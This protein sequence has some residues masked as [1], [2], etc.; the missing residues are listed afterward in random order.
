[1]TVRTGHLARQIRC[2]RCERTFTPGGPADASGTIAL[3]AESTDAT[4][5]PGKQGPFSPPTI[6][7]VREQPRKPW[8]AGQPRHIGRFEVRGRLGAGAFGTVYRAYDPHLDREVAL[9]VP[10]AGAVDS[11]KAVERFLREAK[12]AAGLRHPHIV[13][14]YDAGRDGD[15][16]YIASAFI[17]GRTLSRAISNGP[18]DFRQAAQIVHD[19]AEALGYAHALGIIHRDVKSSNVMLDDQGKCHLMDFG[20]AYRQDVTEKLTHDGTVLGTPAYMAPEQARGKSGDALPASDQYSLGV[21]LYELLCGETPFSGPPQIVLFNVLHQDPPAPRSLRSKIPRELETIC[22]KAMAKVPESRYADC[23]EL[24]ADLRRW[25]EGEPI[26][27]RPL[28]PVDRMLRWCRREPTLAITAALATCSLVAVAV[29]SLLSAA[30]L[31]ES[32]QS[33]RDAREL[34]DKRSDELRVEEMK[35]RQALEDTLRA[36]A[37]RKEEIEKRE[38]AVRDKEEVAKK[39]VHESTEKIAALDAKQQQ[40]VKTR[41]LL[42]DASFKLSLREWDTAHVLDA[43][44]LLG[45]LEPSARA[46]E[47]HYLNRLVSRTSL[48]TLPHTAPVNAVAY[49]PN[50]KRLATAADDGTVRVW[51]ADKEAAALFT[52]TLPRI[53]ARAVAYSLDGTLLASAW[54]DGKVRFHDPENGKEVFPPLA[55]STK[56]LTCLAFHPKQPWLV[57][58]SAD[59]KV[60]RWSMSKTGATPFALPGN[61]HANEV[62]SLA[63]S[64]DGNYLTSVSVGEGADIKVWDFH[65]AGQLDKLKTISAP[66][67]ALLVKKAGWTS[68]GY[69]PLT[70]NAGHHSGITSIAFHP[71]KLE[72]VLGSPN[73]SITMVRFKLSRI[74]LPDLTRLIGPI[75]IFQQPEIVF[76][77]A[78]HDGAVHGLVYCPGTDNRFASSSTDRTIKV[79]DRHRPV[80]L[81]TFKGHFDEVRA[82]A[83]NPQ[84]TRLASAS[85]DA[86]VKVWDL[87]SKQEALQVPTGEP[88][89]VQAVAFGPDRDRPYLAFGG[90]WPNRFGSKPKDRPDRG[91]LR[92]WDPR[93]GNTVAL[94]GHKQGVTCVAFGHDG[95]SLRLASAGLDDKVIVWDVDRSARELFNFQ[96]EQGGLYSVA[97]S[98]DARLLA[99]AGRDGT[100]KI[101]DA[102]NR[103]K[104]L[105]VVPAQGG[106]VFSVAFSPDGKYLIAGDAE[107]K[108]RFWDPATA[109]EARA[110]LTHG[111]MVNSVAISPDGKLLASAG[112]DQV[113]KVWNI[114]AGTRVFELKGHTDGVMSVAFTPDSARLASASLDGVVKVWD[115]KSGQDILSLRALTSNAMSV[116]FSRDGWRLA[117]ADSG[118]SADVYD[119]TP[120]RAT[121]EPKK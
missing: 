49:S 117:V 103:G 73:R 63:F 115:V 69:E 57:A 77:G 82:L 44:R 100:V 99:T 55:A 81:F 71:S 59:R 47:W 38:A 14:V 19:L 94:A 121:A 83:A 72:C 61:T 108:L 105:R 30:R 89:P 4:A 65:F 67:Y 76:L 43:R 88:G 15:R 11:H 116:A 27:A 113:V 34:A 39:L 42:Y 26:R 36:Q 50:G 21:I 10:Q 107:G 120:E 3:D 96:A 22:L 28:G 56:A 92:L 51:D 119:A 31:A 79:W 1:M 93:S 40:E 78:G 7:E 46:W 45:E 13:P 114:Q 35:L 29:I 6:A 20:L 68:G 12:A 101:W 80:P 91:D 2:P 86:T 33:E 104:A 87:N 70:I 118:G 54:A 17:S 74:D 110:A 41:Q 60:L 112:S 52:V 109:R 23:R 75:E 84:G 53:A 25:L 111:S 18:M 24:A 8:P 98:P 62:S 32:A 97:F 90:G 48:L 5:P 16:Y 85:R 106:A 37:D 64:P 102:L 58:G 66:L 9:K 95:T